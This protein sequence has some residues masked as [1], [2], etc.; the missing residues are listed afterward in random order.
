MR[1]YFSCILKKR[2]YDFG[3]DYEKLASLTE[4]YVSSDIQLI[5]NDAARCAL[6][7][8]CNITM[9]LLEEAIQNTRPSLNAEEIKRYDAIRARMEGETLKKQDTQRRRIGF[10]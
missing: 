6:K 3:L 1:R 10:N 8:H 7:Q 9:A 4:N 2:P 5:V